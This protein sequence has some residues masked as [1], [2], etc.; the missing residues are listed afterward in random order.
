MVETATEPLAAVA[1]L[2]PPTVEIIEAPVVEEVEPLEPAPLGLR[3]KTAVRVGAW[4]GA[5]LGLVGFLAATAFWAPNATLNEDGRA[6][7][8]A[9]PRGV[10]IGFAL[11]SIA[12]GA[13]V[14]AL[15]RAAASW[16]DPAMQLAS[17]R[18][19]TGWIGAIVGLV[20]GVAGGSLLTGAFG[21]PIDGEV[22][23]VQL[24][25]LA[26]LGVML[27][28]G[29]ILGAITAAIPQIFGTPVSVE[30]DPAEVEEVKG[31]IRHAVT[32]PL[33][34]VLG[35]LLIVLPFAFILFEANHLVGNGAAIIAIIAA[36]GILGFAAL[37]GTKPNVRLTLGE[38]MVALI[39]IGTVLVVLLA[40]LVFRS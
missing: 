19:S 1:V 12:F 18:S 15:S 3:V 24:P 14:A 5:S 6:M 25:V 22:P 13:V 26:T 36:G 8:V 4:T 21:T 34:G 16:R 38:V 11:V 9:T 39:G 2:E 31:R 10:L 23:T 35:L 7:L 30:E 17:S 28:G 29:A 40:V 33:K 37:A 20:L 27:V 32:I